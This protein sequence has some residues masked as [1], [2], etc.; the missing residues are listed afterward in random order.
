MQDIHGVDTRN[1]DE[2]PADGPSAPMNID[3]LPIYLT[4]ASSIEAKRW[5][6]RVATWGVFKEVLEE[7]PEWSKKDGL[8][9]LPGKLNGTE[10]KKNAVEELYLLVLDSDRGD[11]LTEIAARIR[12]L[13]YAAIVHSSYSHL[14]AE[15]KIKFDDY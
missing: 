6:E 8:S 7:H 9:Y 5:E 14:S 1:L 2:E 11:D 15:T 4:I 12:A 13:G 10:R 3:D